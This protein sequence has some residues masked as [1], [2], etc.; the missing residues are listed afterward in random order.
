MKRYVLF[1]FNHIYQFLLLKTH[2]D[3]KVSEKI[4]KIPTSKTLRAS[5]TFLKLYHF[6]KSYPTLKKNSSHCSSNTTCFFYSTISTNSFYLPQTKTTKL[7]KKNYFKNPKG[8]YHLFT[9]P[10][11]YQIIT[12]FKTK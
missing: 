7:V 10:P 3:N 11:F 4:E 8:F 2:H 5:L 9:A 6:I 1:L 12:N